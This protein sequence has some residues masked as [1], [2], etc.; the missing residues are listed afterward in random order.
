MKLRTYSL[1]C[2]KHTNNVTSR[3]ITMTNKMVRDKSKCGKFLSD[4]SRILKQ[5]CGMH[6]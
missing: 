1:A 6:L 4:Q 3:K 2:R 5:N